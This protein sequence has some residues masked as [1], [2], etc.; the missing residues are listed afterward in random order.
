M[1]PLGHNGF[2]AVLWHQGESDANQKDTT[3]TLA[4]KLYRE[5]SGEDHPRFA[6][7]HRL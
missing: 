7:R 2:R 3:R 4:G 1:R 5:C 6:T